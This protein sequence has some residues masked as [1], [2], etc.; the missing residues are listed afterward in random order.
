MES[1]QFNRTILIVFIILAY[2]VVLCKGQQGTHPAS[3][4]TIA[5]NKTIKYPASLVLYK[6]D[7][8][9]PCDQSKGPVIIYNSRISSCFSFVRVISNTDSRQIIDLINS[10]HTY[11]GE[12]V[13]CFD[14]DYALL[15][16]DK[17][18]IAGYISISFSCNKLLST[19]VIKA[20]ES[21]AKGELRKVGFSS[22]GRSQL[23]KL[24]KIK[25]H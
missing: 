6:Y 5:I 25:A 21:Y 15:V 8:Q 3:G 16:M 4:T 2:A 20:R 9:N 19:P 18:N 1:N 14:S 10:V 22:S 13:S 23:L 24:L 12:D 11:G 17:K 7:K